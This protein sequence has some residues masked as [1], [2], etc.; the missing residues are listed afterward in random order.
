MRHLTAATSA[1]C[2]LLAVT[3]PGSVSAQAVGA[4]DAPDSFNVDISATP[5]QI[6]ISA[7]AALPLDVNAGIA[8]SQVGLNSQP[9]IQSSAGPVFVPLLSDVGLLGGP[10]GV[11]ATVV[12]LAPG[13]VVGIPTLFG[14]DPIPVDPSTVDVG[15]LAT[16]VNGLPVPAMPPLGCTSYYPDVP[17]EVECGG[18]VQEFFGFRLGAG[19]ART[20]STGKEDDPS[21]LASRSDASVTGISPV[22]S[23]SLTPLSAGSVASTAESKVAEGRITAVA[24]AQASKLTV[25]GGL[26]VASVNASF[27][28]AMAGTKETLQQSPLRCEIGAVSLAG[29]PIALNEE[30]LT[31]GATDIPSD[32]LGTILGPLSDALGGQSGQVGGADFGSVTITPNPRPSSVVS[33]DGTQITHRFGCL[34]I[35]YRNATS[36]TDVTFTIGAIAVTMSAFLDAPLTG[37]G[38][39]TD[40]TDLSAPELADQGALPELGSSTLALPE[41]PSPGSGAPAPSEQPYVDASEIQL[42]GWGIDGGWFA[43]YAVLALC[44]PVL[45]RYRRLALSPIRRPGRS[46]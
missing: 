16:Q 28:A 6:D 9:R 25:A 2:L 32:P 1:A 10:A 26:T 46:Q 20:T 11:L 5:L 3:A 15:P 13:L 12:R 29:Q 40:G 8:Y 31:L 44:L 30:G 19:S 34:E 7:P 22:S 35:R 36:G 21:S 27:A 18:P 4:G 38:G 23:N 41:V 39:L 14:L 37:D 45:A 42:A 33:P 24:S 43:P 17:N